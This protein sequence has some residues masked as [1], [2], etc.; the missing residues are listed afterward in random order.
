M[1][2]AAWWQEKMN[3][4]LASWTQL[5]HDNLLYAKQSYT[6]GNICS[7]PY[8]YVEPIPGF[9]KALG[10]MASSAR[11]IFDSC[12]PASVWPKTHILYYWNSLKGTADTLESIARKELTNTLLSEGE[13]AFLR[14]F[15]FTQQG[16][17]CGQSPYSGWY[18]QLFYTG[19]E[20]LLKN[21]LVVADVHT[22]PTDESGGMVGWVLHAGTGPINLA[23]LVAEVPGGQNVA[24]I[25]PVMS[26]YE[27]VSTNFKR[28]TDK[29][30]KAGYLTLPALRP[31]FV[32]LYLA[33]ST[34]GKR[35]GPVPSLITS[36]GPYDNPDIPTAIVLEKNFPNPFNSSTIILFSIP[37][38]LS[39]SPVELWVHNVLG[40]R[41]KRLVNQP[42]P[43][44]KYAARWDG[45]NE[46]GQVVASGVYFYSLRV[47]N[48]FATG[49]MSY[50]K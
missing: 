31:D 29:E 13:L 8:S 26:Y 5:R 44:G 15:F 34:G 36:V 24:F 35:P 27:Y 10:Q 33:D 12:L 49:K 41:V 11:E 45:T 30:W 46:R 43:A 42:M 7:F 47:G 23:V 4:Q 38:S 19:V 37:Q 9:Y 3:T 1:K 50:V 22:C 48:Q 14:H 39:N 28:L 21:D 17:V 20:G 40:Q 6:G 25:G 2:T 18:F 32:N 16:I